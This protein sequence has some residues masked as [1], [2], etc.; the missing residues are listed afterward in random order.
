MAN[1]PFKLRIRGKFGCFTRPET[2]AERVSYEIITPPAAI[3][4]FDS[5]YY[6]PGMRWV[7]TEICLLSMPSF[8]NFRRN[9]LKEVPNRNHYMG[10]P[11]LK[12]ELRTQRNSLIL[13]DPDFAVTAHIELVP[14]RLH[15]Y[16]GLSKFE[17]IF[18]TRLLRGQS[19][20]EPYLG[21]S[22]Y[23]ARVEK[24]DPAIHPAPVP[25]D[26][27]FGRVHLGG[28]TTDGEFRPTF[29]PAR[30]EQGVIRVPEVY[31]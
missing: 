5:I 20:Y 23:P 7:V 26:R 27:D 31:F 30:M 28:W 24:Y 17:N 12:E 18:L 16:D 3:G 1:K 14:E 22:E 10:K 2:K 6:H 21:C 29:F 13:R 15:Q 8:Q 9:E 11:Y 4:I 25:E 19:Y